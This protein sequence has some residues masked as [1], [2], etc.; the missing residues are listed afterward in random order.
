MLPLANATKSQSLR[1][2]MRYT[3]SLNTDGLFVILMTEE[4]TG[5]SPHLQLAIFEGSVNPLMLSSAIIVSSGLDI[6]N[7]YNCNERFQRK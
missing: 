4:S 3:A 1:L 2:P 6:P 7:I 5:V